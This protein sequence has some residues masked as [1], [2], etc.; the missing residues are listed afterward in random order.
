MDSA[1]PQA[2]RKI[3]F[4]AEQFV[5]PVVDG[6]TYVYKSWIDFLAERY[7]LYAIF[8][9]S[10]AG[11]RAAAERYLAARCKAHLILPGAPR[12]RL[13]KVARAG[14]RFA[15]GSLLAPGWLVELGRG[16]I[17]RTIAEFVARH[18]PDL[19]HISKL[20]SVPLFGEANLRDTKA[21]F[22]LDMHDD[23]VLRDRI[24]RE[25]L[26]RLLSAY[27]AMAPYPTFRNLRLRQALSRLVPRRA[28]AQEA[29]LC[30]LFDAILASSLDE[31]RFYREA[32]GFG[33]RCALVGW[34]PRRAGGEAGAP[35]PEGPP[36]F[37]AG[38][39]GGN[40]PF[41]V[42]A[43]LFFLNEILPLIRQR[44]PD[45]RFL[46]AGK[47]S[48]PLA[49]AGAQWPGVAFHGYVPDAR[50]FYAQI[51]VAVVPVLSG[52][53]VSLKT[54]EAL[55]FG[56]PVV[57][58]RV[59]VRGLE[60]LEGHPGLLLAEGA[61]DFAAKTIGILEGR[62]GAGAGSSPRLR[63]A[64]PDLSTEAFHERFERLMTACQRRA[65]PLEG[66]RPLHAAAEA[67]L[68]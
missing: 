3:V 18:R 17:H 1:A 68:L 15:T 16:A 20:V 48:A 9:A 52:T 49:L 58:T 47:A 5:P 19:F 41:N 32:P 63:Q 31:F 65:D 59:G 44:R 30:G 6:S 26:G 7:E 35:A 46:V 45:F 38:F 14:A 2:R 8:F 12:R 29:R 51:R 22:L 60:A 37:D 43:L 64:A 62:E 21:T 24:E 25:V 54:V 42:E 50:A 61:A 36:S 10:Y 67:A 27:P 13:W 53:G 40:H 66:T 33:A 28:R 11:E 34:P 23:F 55:D 4:V 39:I 56:R 57:A